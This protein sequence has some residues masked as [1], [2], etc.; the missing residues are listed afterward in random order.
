MKSIIRSKTLLL[1]LTVVLAA[2][3]T[4]FAQVTVSPEFLN[5]DDVPVG[6]TVSLPLVIKN[7][8]DTTIAVN[9]INFSHSYFQVSDTSFFI[10]PPDSQIIVVTFSPQDQGIADGTMSILVAAPS[11]TTLEVELTGWTP[12]DLNVALARNEYLM[13]IS[14]NLQQSRELLLHL[15]VSSETNWSIPGSESATLTI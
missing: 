7:Q 2:N 9:D 15:R 5:F 14:F 6:Q 3:H 4:V 11:D 13:P 1:C 12:I 10:A 8:G